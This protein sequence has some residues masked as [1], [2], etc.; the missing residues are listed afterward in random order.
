MKKSYHHH[1][2]VF[3]TFFFFIIVVHSS[4]SSDLQELIG[5]VRGLKSFK[6]KGS[7]ITFDCSPSG[8]CVPCLYHEKKDVS[9]RCSET[10]YRIPMKCVKTV[11]DESNKD[12]NLLEEMYV[13]YRSCIPAVNQ[14]K[15]S[16]LA[17]E[18]IMLLL[19]ITSSFVIFR[20]KGNFVMPGPIR[21][22]TNPRF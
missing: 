18:G 22:P 6:E 15:L 19:L 16:L 9:Y 17:F 1:R 21:L 11:D 8:P 2:L 12:R 20:R 7:N 13:T 5:G 14:E 10:G 4:S 3:I